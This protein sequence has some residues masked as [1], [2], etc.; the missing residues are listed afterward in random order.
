VPF[1][2][3]IIADAIVWVTPAQPGAT[4]LVLAPGGLTAIVHLAGH[5]PE[6]L[7]TFSFAGED[8]A[9]PAASLRMDVGADP[10]GWTVPLQGGRY[11]YSLNNWGPVA[12][13]PQG[14]P[15]RELGQDVVLQLAWSPP[16][17]TP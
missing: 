7:V 2:A 1:N 8:A 16:S 13:D 10:Q 17:R 5:D 12:D 9:D 4:C 6:A 15:V 14:S 3:R 11:C